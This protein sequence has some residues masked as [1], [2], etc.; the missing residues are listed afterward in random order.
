M[1]MGP[2]V[3][4]GSALFPPFPLGGLFRPS[5][6]RHESCRTR[7]KFP[8]PGRFSAGRQP[9]TGILF[10]D[11][12]TAGAP[13]PTRRETSMRTVNRSLS[14]LLAVLAAGLLA[15]AAAA[16]P[17]DPLPDAK[18]R[19]DLEAQKV[20][21]WADQNIDYARYLAQQGRTAE[22]V[23]YVRRV[24]DYVKNDRDLPEARR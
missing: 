9:T 3:D 24:L 23:D 8:T 11:E 7:R 21:K 2:G 17:R 15:G 22:A 4:A 14:A 5:G 12:A 18:Q 19:Q 10:T 1:T 16:Q 20:E 13:L 6:A